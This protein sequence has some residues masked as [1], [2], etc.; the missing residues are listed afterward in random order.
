MGLSVCF[1]DC[2]FRPGTRGARLLVNAGDAATK[3]ELRTAYVQILQGMSGFDVKNLA[4]MCRATLAD[5]SDQPR[6][7]LTPRLPEFSEAFPGY[8]TNDPAISPA[9]GHFIG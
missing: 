2:R 1:L 3:M 5:K 6:G 4:A 9:L 8:M 7:V